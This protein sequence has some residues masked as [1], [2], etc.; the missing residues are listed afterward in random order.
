MSLMRLLTVSTLFSLFIMG[1][2]TSE[3]AQKAN[4]C[5]PCAKDKKQF[6]STHV[7]DYAKLVAMGE[8]MWNDDKL[9]KSGMSCMTCHADHQFLNLERHHGQWPHDIPKMTDD[10]VTL[11]QMTNY[12][13]INPMQG[14]PIDPNSVEMTA[15]HAYYATYIKSFKGAKPKARKNPCN[16]CAPRS[17]KANPCNPCAVK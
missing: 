12:C 6:R 16:P 14:E 4:P 17:K 9:G 5:N 1:A 11:T 13:M 7:T 15:M 2:G 8:K 10:I 3:G